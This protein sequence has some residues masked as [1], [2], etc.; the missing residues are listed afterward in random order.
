MNPEHERLLQ[1]FE[2]ME[3]AQGVRLFDVFALG[4]LMIYAASRLN[5][6]NMAAILAL[7]GVGTIIFNGVNYLRIE[8]LKKGN[9][10]AERKQPG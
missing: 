10:N 5:S 2:A 4:P 8:E 1:H 6:P 3:K 9:G 7:S